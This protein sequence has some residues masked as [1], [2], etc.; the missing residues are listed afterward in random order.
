MIENKIIKMI[1]DS[2][3][4]VITSHEN[5]DGDCIGSM[6]ALYIALKKKGKHVRMIL[7][8]NVPANLSFLPYTEEIEIVREVKET[9]ELLVL[10]DTGE[11]ER[12]GIFDI[13]K[14]YKK[15]INIDHHAT[16]TGLGDLYYINP[17]AAASGEIIYQLVKLMGI[18]TDKDI[19]TCLYTA[20]FTDTGGFRFS[21]TTSITHQIAGDLIN[22]GIDFV[23]IANKV[24][25]EMSLNKFKLLRD[26]LGTIELFDNNKIAFL[27]VSSEMFS[28][29]GAK[30]EDTE[31]MIN[32]AKNIN[33]VEIAAIFI[34]ESDKIKV[35]LRSKNILDV[36]KIAKYFGGGGHE[37]AAGYSTNKKI[38]DAKK[39]LLEKIQSDERWMEY[40]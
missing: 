13:D 3:Q 6:L 40:Y 1:L 34:E 29:N 39:D 19:G 25:D 37:K 20:L 21:N 14:A 8:D 18:D 16:S 7:K 22:M 27:T 15:L 35:S 5:P 33:T 26:V 9:F 11:L 10:I 28:K 23:T 32:F 30:R 24:Y 36:S 17:S 38:E 31:N 12:T 2:S 4:I